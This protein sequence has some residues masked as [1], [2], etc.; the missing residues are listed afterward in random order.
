MPTSRKPV[1][2]AVRK[3]SPK[4]A[5][6]RKKAAD[7]FAALPPES[8]RQMEKWICLACVLDV[9]T[10]H[11]GLPPKTAHL[12]VK[13]YTPSVPELYASTLTRPYFAAQSPQDPCPY[14][15]SAP[16]KGLVRVEAYSSGTDGVYRLTSR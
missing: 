10:R 13:R 12:E 8:V 16:K 3:P 6:A 14:C 7:P 1:R 9:F 2:K 5:A 4:K 15:G 11:M